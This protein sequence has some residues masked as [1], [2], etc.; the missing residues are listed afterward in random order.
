M[1]VNYSGY[2]H[3]GGN[4]KNI[5]ILLLLS[6]S[7]GT[8]TDIEGRWHLVGYEDNVMYQFEDNYR[9]S[10]YSLD[11]TFGGLEDAG[12]SPN[13]YT[14]EDNIITLDLFFGIIANY[15]MNFM[16]D[17]QVVEFKNID[18]GTI[19]STH[20]REGYNYQESPCN[21]NGECI[22]T[23]CSSQ[24]CAEE[25]ISSDCAYLDWY[26]C[27]QYSECGNYGLGGNCS[28]LTTDLFL[29]CLD[30]FGV[31]VGCTD[32][33]AC[34]YDETATIDDGDCEY[35][36]PEIMCDC[37]GNVED[38]AGTCGGELELDCG[39]VCGGDNSTALSCCGLPF[40]EDCTT[41]CYEDSMGTCCIEEDADYCGM[42]FGG[43]ISC[44]GDV[45]L[46]GTINV[47]DIVMVVD[48]ILSNNYD[49]VGDVNEDGQLNVIDIVM[50]VDWV[51]NGMPEADSDGDGVIDEDD[52]DPNNPYQ[53]SDLDGDTCDDCSTG[54]VSTF[55][56]GYDYDGDGQC[57]DGDCDDDN[58]GCQ[59]C[60]DY[61]P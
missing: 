7:F 6:L 60:W 34:N 48:L 58:D 9:Y 40:Y 54:T 59:E 30:S 4:M 20:F 33:E 32:P 19:H 15:Q 24:I 49:L 35:Y 37:D 53:C 42:C 41:D 22:I 56:D 38:C 44:M 25:P 12:G 26:A 8:V 11:D 51:L 16:C 17:G 1:S 45:N 21:D 46:D 27:F 14:V 29:D 18:Y 43:N 39:G 3:S 31:N 13:P 57:D 28:W 47:I 2:I 5:Y 50:L 52:S 55:D 23:G 36:D 10:I 61:C